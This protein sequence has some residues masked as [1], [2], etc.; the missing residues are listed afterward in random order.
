MIV[1]IETDVLIDV[2]LDRRHFSD[3]A[4]RLLDVVQ[5]A[6]AV[7]CHAD[8]IATR[9]FRDYRVPGSRLK[10]QAVLTALR[11]QTQNVE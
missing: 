4:G 2:A 11:G 9:N 5:C 3:P 1:L 7:P 8:V 6:G 10:P